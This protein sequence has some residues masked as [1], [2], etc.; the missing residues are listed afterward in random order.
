MLTV[1]I[2]GLVVNIAAYLILHGAERANLNVKGALLHV[3]GD[4]LG[5]V[6]AIVAALV[7]L[8]TGWTPIDPLLSILVAVVILRSAW[9]LA[10]ES[11]HILLEGAPR[12][13]DVEAMRDDL[14]ASVPGVEDIHHVHAWALTQERPMVTLHARIANAADAPRIS[15][16]IK[17]HLRTRYRISHA[18]VEVECDACA[19]DGVTADQPSP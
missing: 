17:A 10:V 18:T 4:L 7:I 19:D 3:I 8:T 5:S 6:A 11:G 9:F 14:V 1:A 12:D 2:A 16:A 13:L 15:L